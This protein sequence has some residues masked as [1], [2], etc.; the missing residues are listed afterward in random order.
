MFSRKQISI[1]IGLITILNYCQLDAAR[2]VNFAN[3]TKSPQL[4]KDNL[5]FTLLSADGKTEFHV[6][7]FQSSIDL[8]QYEISKNKP[9]KLMVAGLNLPSNVTN[10][11]PSVISEILKPGTTYSITTKSL[12]DSSS[13]PSG[14]P[15]QPSIKVYL[16][17]D[18]VKK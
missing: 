7:T 5:E 10:K 8:D 13:P 12:A 14:Y 9:V 6:G 11:R 16:H 18:P 2:T 15:P 4:S 17:I 3:N 1:F